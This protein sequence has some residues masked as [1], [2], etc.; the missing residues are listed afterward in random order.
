MA[1]NDPQ[2]TQ[3]KITVSEL[4]LNDLSTRLTEWITPRLGAD[5]PVRIT[6]IERPDAGMSGATVLFDAEWTKSNVA[7]SGSYVLRMPP[8]SIPLMRTYDLAK[9]YAVMAAV[10]AT[11]AVPVPELC[12]EEKD[13]TALGAPFFIMRKVEG[14]IPS[15]NP[16][17][18]FLGWI[19]ESSPEAR[20][21]LMRNTVGVLAS[22]HTI[23]DA[24]QRFPML[25]SEG[26]SLRCHVDE[27]RAWYRWA[28]ADDGHVVPLIEQGLDWLEAHWPADSA[29][30]V[31]SWGDARPANIIYDGIDPAAVIDWEMAALGPRELDVAWII[32]MHAFFQFLANM[33][34]AAGLPDFLRRDD[35]VAC[36]QEIS[37]HELRDL[38]F[39]LVYSA[40]R[41]AIAMA[42]GKVRMIKFGEDV[43]PQDPD[44]Y[45]MQRPLLAAL[46]NGTSKW[47]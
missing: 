8:T 23:P 3:W 47:E 39:F 16:P 32:Y 27:T 10:A 42:R 15:D 37:G 11:G 4:G 41:H 22:L 40:V 35:V 5:E 17:Y 34:G 1:V 6:K 13:E 26:S 2:R 18:V 33:H 24:R 9:Q 46:L 28:L 21:Q 20:T 29:P 36:Y 38:D 30:D 45:I 14:R 12:W 25:C 31:L 19:P 7:F 43:V 44:D